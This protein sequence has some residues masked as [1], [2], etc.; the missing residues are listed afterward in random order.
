MRKYFT[1]YTLVWKT[2]GLFLV[3]VLLCNTTSAETNAE[4]PSAIPC[5]C[6]LTGNF[7]ED[8]IVSGGNCILDNATVTASVL[9]YDG[10]QLTV[11]NGST[12]CGNI[13]SNRGGNIN[14]KDGSTVLG[15]VKLNNGGELTVSGEVGSIQV[16]SGS[17]KVDI[18]G[19]TINGGV[20]VNEFSGDITVA[21]SV[22]NNTSID[23]AIFISEGNGNIIIKDVM[24]ASS[25]IFVEKQTG[26]V[27]VDGSSFSDIEVEELNGDIALFNVTG[28]SGAEFAEISGVVFLGQSTFEGDVELKDNNI[29]LI[30]GN[31]FS[32]GN[33]SVSENQGQVIIEQNRNLSLNV[34]KNEEIVAIENNTNVTKMEVS[35][36]TNG[37]I[38]AGNVGEELTCA[39][40]SPFLNC[41]NNDFSFA[42]GQCVDCGVTNRASNPVDNVNDLLE[43]ALSDKRLMLECFP[44]PFM[45]KTTI[46]F[47]LPEAT[48]ISISIID[49]LGKSSVLAS[50]YYEAGRHEIRWG[51]DRLVHGSYILRL[52]AGDLSKTKRVF[53]EKDY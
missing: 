30:V 48:D 32:L 49:L 41:I 6:T 42:D 38:I 27:L 3:S 45:E 44:N 17:G 2:L 11:Q 39:N 28:D 21:N 7:S 10:G 37:V 53:F 15:K 25:D 34:S 14:V 12:I 4:N 46:H 31:D 5:N 16:Y 13:K 23:G 50:G 19:A 36:N 8:I 9:V 29:V 22:T 35:K 18:L 1:H 40:N 43:E 51:S 33:V 47:V 52:K 26:N 24:L 20:C